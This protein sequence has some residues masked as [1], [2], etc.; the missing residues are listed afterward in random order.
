MLKRTLGETIDLHVA[1]A[2]KLWDCEADAAQLQNA[3]INLA[4]NARDAMPQG[5]KLTIETANAALDEHYAAAHSEV[6][7]GDYV[8]LGISDSGT[9]MPP[10]VIERAF[11]PFFTTKE[12]GRGSGLGLSMVYGFVKQSRGHVKIYSE[13]G[14]GTTVRVYLPR[15]DQAGAGAGEP[16][17]EQPVS[18]SETVLVV[19]DDIEV[20]ALALRLLSGLG[21]GALAAGSAAAALEII[22]GAEPVDL[23]L[24]DVVLPGGTN[25]RALANKAKALRPG[26][27]VLYMSGYTE[28]A[29]LHHGRLDPGVELLQKPFRRK[30]LADKVRAAL[31]AGRKTT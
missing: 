11:D 27:A 14:L 18:G 8:A 5:G 7:P 29:I 6:T 30:N 16:E 25:G 28:N 2:P 23:L 10:E 21:Y 19:E 20:R 31:E 9:G 3:L 13:V 22:A 24:T 17:A 26:L 4:L 12:A 1:L 15:S